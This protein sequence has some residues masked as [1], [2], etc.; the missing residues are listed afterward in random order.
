MILHF[1]LFVCSIDPPKTGSYS[2][3]RSFFKDDAS[4]PSSSGKNISN[5]GIASSSKIATITS[6]TEE[7]S[8]FL[9]NSS[10]GQLK[11]NFVAFKGTGFKLGGK[12][13][14][15]YDVN[16]LISSSSGFR[17]DSSSTFKKNK[18]SPYSKTSKF[19]QNSSFNGIKTPIKGINIIICMCACVCNNSIKYLHKKRNGQAVAKR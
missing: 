14:G 12:S 7:E 10:T 6:V 3:I 1:I 13:L 9:T 2:D 19:P 18:E 11:T 5:L 16:P 4:K 15:E 8:N 17:K